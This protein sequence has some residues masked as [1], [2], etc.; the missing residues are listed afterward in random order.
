MTRDPLGPDGWDGQLPTPPADEVRWDGVLALL[1]EVDARRDA[2]ADP[3]REP[4]FTD[5]GVRI[6]DF[7]GASSPV[8]SALGYLAQTDLME[9]GFDWGSFVAS[10]RAL[11]LRERIFAAA[12]GV[13]EAGEVGDMTL[14]E[15]R[16]FLIALARQERFSSGAVDGA[17]RSGFVGVVLRR[18]RE[19]V[20]D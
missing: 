20:Q 13:R 15:C 18:A 2:P 9:G 16:M 14:E 6:V 8:A 10:P 19:L 17:L 5:D 12:N 11:L 3:P 4:R 7:S 1:A